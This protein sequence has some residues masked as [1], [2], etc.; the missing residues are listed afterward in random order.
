MQE[1]LDLRVGGHGRLIGAWVGCQVIMADD[2]IPDWRL[3]APHRPLE[4]GN[5]VY[6]VR[7]A[8]GGDAIASWIMAGGNTVLVGGPTGAGKSTELARAAQALSATRVACM[9]QVDRMTNV[10]RLSA[11]ELM[12]LI[13]RRLVT[14][15][16]EQLPVPLSEELV[17]ATSH[18]FPIKDTGFF[19]ASSPSLVRA[20][21]EEIARRSPQGRIALLI[22]GLEKL[23]PGSS[24][25]EI[26]EALS[27]LPD[28]VDLIVVIP[29]HSVF[30]G[31]TESIL[32]AGE[33]LHR[34][35]PLDTVGP[36]AGDTKSFFL[37]FLAGRL[38]NIAL[39]KS[40]WPQFERAVMNS[41]GIP[42]IFLQLVADAGTYAR[43]KRGAAWPD[44]SDLS[45]AITDQ[46]DSFRRALLPGDTQAIVAVAGTD[47]RELDL[48]RRVRLL[49]H[50]ILLERI[51]DGRL[52]LEIHPLA[53]PAVLHPRT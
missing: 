34:I 5:G 15:A 17:A 44:D 9:V 16:G 33:R 52:V 11:D 32:R 3:L 42:R 48:E 53:A 4:P 27:A 29:W 26:F 14:I 28:A 24:A 19:A 49:A 45:D 1:L 50:G 12:G 20:A 7:P 36:S 31:G 8:G 13:A 6:V 39:P 30:G 37:S 2:P 18:P 22:D 51:R 40:L 46:Q 43:V 41:G 38:R 25:R 21:L 10:H 35:L 47:G 23:S